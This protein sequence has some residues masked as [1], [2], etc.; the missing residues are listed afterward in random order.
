M[1]LFGCLAL[2]VFGLGLVVAPRQA[3][4]APEPSFSEQARAAALSETIRLRDAGRALGQAAAGTPEPAAGTAADALQ[5][6]M[7][8]TVRLLTTQAQALL[9]PD[10]GAGS[11]SGA[12]ESSPAGTPSPGVPASPADTPG[13]AAALAAALAESGGH[14][15]ADA[16][17]AEGGMARLLAAVGTAQLLASAALAGPAG[18]GTHLPAALTSPEPSGSCPQGSATS[19]PA[20]APT[21]TPLPTAAQDAGGGQT[22]TEQAALAAAV[23]AE[24]ATVYAYQV[25][26]TRL[27]GDAALTASGHLDRHEALLRAAESL[28]RGVCAP[29]PP[30][31]AGYALDPGF[32]SAPAAGLGGL[33]TA[34][35]PVY[36][37]VIALSSGETR[38]WAI[39]A[40]LETARRAGSWGADPGPLPGLTADPALFPS[41]PARH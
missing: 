31:E 35:L 2:F 13:S 16:G 28:S 20:P 22:A 36:G 25:A 17:A 41:L 18:A 29:V 40:L 8:T 37:D 26:L 5:P 9:A 3:V 14:R 39:A 21:S 19:T 33:E 4:E 24:T 30:R 11:G 1:A 10:A 27:P 38:Q 34:M 15:L 6:G 23:R 7:D 32:L 12:A